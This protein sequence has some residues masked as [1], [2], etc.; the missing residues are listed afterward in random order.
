MRGDVSTTSRRSSTPETALAMGAAVANWFATAA[1]CAP[2]V[3]AM[4]FD[5]DG[6]L[7]HH[8]HGLV[9]TA[10]RPPHAGTVYRIA[11]MSK[12]FTA[13]LIAQLDE[14]GVLSLDDAVS[15]WV[16]HFPDYV[17]KSG[18]SVSVSVRS[19]VTM[20]SGLPEDNAWADY[21]AGHDATFLARVLTD[22]PSFA[23]PPSTV[24]QYSN[25][26]YAV[27]GL[28][29]EAAMHEPFGVVATRELLE[30]LGL[31]DTRWSLADF[32]PS[33]RELAPGRES[34][35]GGVSWIDRPAVPTGMMA[36]A[37]S[38]FSTAADVARWATW[39]GG[40][41]D[42][43]G[44]D[45]AVLSRQ[46]R[47]AMQFGSTP[48]H[49]MEPRMS[50]PDLDGIGYGM[51]LLVEMDPRFGK[52]I[53]H[54]GGLPGF[55][56]NMRWH[57]DSGIGIV[58]LANTNGIPV[59]SW[60]RGLLGDLLTLAD[61]AASRVEVWPETREAARVIDLAIRE[62]AGFASAL[63]VF[64]DNVVSDIPLEVRDARLADAL[65]RIGGISA[66]QPPLEERLSWTTGPAQLVWSITGVTGA[67]HCL[68]ETA[69]TRGRRVQRLDVT[70]S[71]PGADPPLVVR[72][73]RPRIERTADVGG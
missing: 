48:V 64:D 30:P 63:R 19:L 61:A 47:R 42:P 8:G 45:D 33:T 46:A 44:G 17:E 13:A 14:R 53:Q 1:P 37:G 26:S 59:A 29:V 71:D 66:V 20:S 54:S 23:A 22:G 5:R 6:P 43:A 15:R 12:S 31:H 9:D 18:R 35:D 55:A 7:V 32:G 21:Y 2:S 27:L 28:V 72:H 36:P 10:G 65:A 67:L 40:A 49:S 58:M 25:L 4:V 68:I 34:Y 70:L 62:S 56:S 16:P 38:L 51:G 57:A 50:R 73:Y 41:F 52:I 69:P 24:Y 60:S 11:S 3:S 39:L